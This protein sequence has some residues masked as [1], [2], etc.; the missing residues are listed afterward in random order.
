MSLWSK[1]IDKLTF[2]DAVEFEED[3]TEAA[4]LGAIQNTQDLDSGAFITSFTLST[5]SADI[6]VS[7]GEI[8]NLGT[9]TWSI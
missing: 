4:F 1:P 7:D 6:S 9:I 3:V 5:P 2:Q 8:A